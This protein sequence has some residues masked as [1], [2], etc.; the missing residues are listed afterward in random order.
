MRYK[1]LLLAVTICW[2]VPLGAQDKGAL[3][4]PNEKISYGIGVNIGSAWKA[5]EI[6][7]LNLELVVQGIKDALSGKPP[8]L[9]QEEINTA[10]NTYQAEL[11][12]RQTEK[13]KQLGEK[14][15]A[16]GD[17]FL[18][19][20]KAKPGVTTLPSGLQ[21]KVLTAGNGATPSK[22]DTVTV[23]YR[24]TLIDGTEFDSSYTR[25]KPA[26]FN[27]SGVIAGWTEALQLMKA[28]SKWQLFIPSGLAY[29]ESGSGQR[30]GPNAAL[31]FEVELLGTESPPPTPAPAPAAAPVVTSDII[32]V[33]S[34]EELK[35]GAKIEVIKPEDLEKKKEP[36]KKN[37]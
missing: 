32:K 25:G 26:T 22:N 1:T 37:E 33:P 13:R 11:Q 21:Y 17:K 2:A 34:A 10:L 8:L 3:K 18:A 14:N 16:E 35:K 24:G 4:T 19:E 28:G 27:A 36:E 20:N 29:R 31:I 12:T 6:T 5:R 7:D 15:K 9:A 23:N 30:I